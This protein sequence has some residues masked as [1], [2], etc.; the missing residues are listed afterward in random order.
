MNDGRQVSRRARTPKPHEAERLSKR[1]AV[2]ERRLSILRTELQIAGRN[3]G[4][5]IGLE[6]VALRVRR[7]IAGRYLTP[8]ESGNRRA[9]SQS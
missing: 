5:K 3:N 2:L 7:P 6:R 9:S 1:I 8:A 4:S